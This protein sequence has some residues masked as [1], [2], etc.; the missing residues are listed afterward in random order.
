M[1]LLRLNCF[2][3]PCDGFNFSVFQTKPIWNDLQQPQQKALT[4]F[5][6]FLTEDDFYFV[7]VFPQCF[8]RTRC[9]LWQPQSCTVALVHVNSHRQHTF[10]QWPVLLVLGSS[11][12]ESGSHWGNRNPL[13]LEGIWGCFICLYSAFGQFYDPENCIEK[14]S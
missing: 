13:E 2:F 11:Q 5:F 1:L 12:T 6:F 14:H 7:L 9:W 3:C 8:R 10:V 4:W